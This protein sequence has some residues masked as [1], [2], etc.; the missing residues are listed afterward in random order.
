MV[1]WF[2]SWFGVRFG[3][4]KIFRFGRSL[5]RTKGSFSCSASLLETIEAKGPKLALF[6]TWEEP[7]PKL[8]FKY[9]YHGRNGGFKRTRTIYYPFAHHNQPLLPDF[10]SLLLFVCVTSNRFVLLSRKKGKKKLDLN[11]TLF[12]TQQLFAAQLCCSW[13]TSRRPFSQV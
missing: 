12:A 9:K 5:L 11:I 1:R 8:S 6:K 2:R 7:N 13:T 4:T 10:F 3:R